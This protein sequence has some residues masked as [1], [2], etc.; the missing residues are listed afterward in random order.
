MISQN[1]DASLGNIMV[2][3]SDNGGHKPEFWADVIT[4]RLVSISASAEPHVRQ[5][6]EAFRQQVYEVVLRG[7]KSAI[8]S[9]RTT[10]S[11]ALRRQGHHQMAD[12]LKEL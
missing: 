10:L 4:T 2:A 1:A 5:Q 9:D 12:L 3:S 6:A 11:V 7:I 8:S